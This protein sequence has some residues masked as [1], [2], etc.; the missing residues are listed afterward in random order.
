M[1]F[2]LICHTTYIHTKNEMPRCDSF[3]SQSDNLLASFRFLT[4]LE[5]GA[6]DVSVVVSSGHRR[7]CCSKR[8]NVHGVTEANTMEIAKLSDI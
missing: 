1:F 7:R 5:F 8:S 6:V 4:T 2:R 3:G